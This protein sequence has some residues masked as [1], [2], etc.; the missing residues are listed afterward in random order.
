V[1]AND[2]DSAIAIDRIVVYAVDGSKLCDLAGPAALGPRQSWVFVSVLQPCIPFASSNVVGVLRFVVWWSHAPTL[3][4]QHALRLN[5]L[6]GNAAILVD[7]AATFV[8]R[9]RSTRE[10]KPIFD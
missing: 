3:P 8:V 9:G 10:C 5:P 6:D 7:D 2:N 4:Q 1:F